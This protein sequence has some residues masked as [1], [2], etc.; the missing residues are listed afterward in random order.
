MTKPATE[1]VALHNVT[2]RFG[3]TVG[4]RNASLSILNG[5]V[6]SLVGE[7]GAGKSTLMN[8]LY[9]VHQPDQGA[10]VVRGSKV[11][12]PNP[13]RAISLGIGM[14]HQ[15]FKLVPSFTV[16]ENIILGCEPGTGMI[17]PLREANKRV[18]ALSKRFDLE[19]SP[20]VTVGD[21]P[22][23]LQQRVE[24]LKA[25][26]R[27]ISI[28]ILDEPTAVLTP[29]ETREL[30]TTMRRLATLDK[31][32]IFI[33]HKL[34]E[35]V[36]VSDRI[37]VMRH[38]EIIQTVSNNNVS[39]EDIATAMVGRPVLLRVSKEPSNPL[40]E[41]LAVDHLDVSGDRNVKAVK[42]VSF[43]VRCGEIVGVAGVQG[44][45]QDELIEAITG[46]RKPLQGRVRVLNTDVTGLPP[47]GVRHAGLAF[48]PADRGR[49]GLSLTSSVWENLTVNRQVKEQVSF[50]PILNIKEAI[51]RT[52]GLI[53]K[54]DIRAA[55]PLTLASAL[56]GGNQQ[57]VVLA[58]ELSTDAQVV[59][60]DQPSRG[61]DIGAIESIHRLLVQMRDAGRAVLLVSADLDEIFSLS[62]RILVMYKGEIVGQVDAK[63]TTVEEVGRL[64][65]GLYT[66]DG[67]RE[68]QHA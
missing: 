6:H 24:I 61:V 41:G 57:K 66:R 23:G 26:Y 31:S 38:G 65:G 22:V 39:P 40:R 28:L 12:I 13:A 48:V 9:G 60:V 15:H 43:H 59:I 20:T 63:A 50:G 33:T 1:I 46:F 56:S 19:L 53:N 21:L 35:V 18:L 30:F 17:L 14:V 67:T 29:Q 49:V 32:I 5:E 44:N 64:M 11:S 36:E 58:R 4:T 2:K 54:F 7:N 8:I 47:F 68:R 52:S 62:D 42:G 27:D 45:G 34:K 37:S 25:L 51:R 3:S 55:T 10:L 16:A